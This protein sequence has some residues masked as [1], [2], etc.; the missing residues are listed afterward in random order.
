MSMDIETQPRVAE[1]IIQEQRN[2]LFHLL[3]LP[4]KPGAQT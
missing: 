2:T 1:M 3:P 4:S